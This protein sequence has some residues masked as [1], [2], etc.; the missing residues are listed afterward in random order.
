MKFSTAVL[1]LSVSLA[2]S[3]AQATVSHVFVS[4]SGNGTIS[5]IK[6]VASKGKKQGRRHQF[7]LARQPVRWAPGVVVDRP[8]RRGRRGQGQG[9]AEPPK[10][11]KQPGL[12]GYL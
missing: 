1:T 6:C 4:N 12:C 8:E 10:E 3:A 5:V 9:V 11:S 7:Q 2:F